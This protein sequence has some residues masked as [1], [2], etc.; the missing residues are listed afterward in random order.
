MRKRIDARDRESEI[1]VEFIGNPEDIGLKAEPKQ[2]AVTGVRAGRLLDLEIFDVCGT[3][4]DG[5][6]ALPTFQESGPIRLTVTTRTGS[7][8]SEPVS[9]WPWRSE[10]SSATEPEFPSFLV[11]LR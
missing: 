10:L 2:V 1:R 5:P 6:E 3:E 9:T 8:N 11:K 7:P 4:R